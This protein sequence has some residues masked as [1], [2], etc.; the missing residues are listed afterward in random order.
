MPIPKIDKPIKIFIQKKGK[1]VPK[2]IPTPIPHTLPKE[3]TFNLSFLNNLG[4]ISFQSI[5]ATCIH[6]CGYQLIN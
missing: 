1:N 3:R 6:T 5:L 4:S 2:T